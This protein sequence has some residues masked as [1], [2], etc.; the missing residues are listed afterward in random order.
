MIIKRN[1]FAIVILTLCSSVA[2]AQ[3][4]NRTKDTINTE[5]VNVVKPYTPKISDAFKVKEIPS[6]EDEVTENRKEVKY[7]IFSIPVAST[8]TPAKAKAAAV[9]KAEPVKLYDN[10]ASFGVGSYTSFLGEVYLNHAINSSETVGGYVSHHSSAGGIDGVVLDDNF[11]DT[12]FNAN[13]SRKSSDYSWNVDAGARHQVFNWYGIPDDVYD[14]AAISSIDPQHTYFTFD[15]GG[16]IE[17]EDRLL[18]DGR[19]RFRRFADDYDSGENRFMFSTNIDIP[20][21][22]GELNTTFKF[23]YLGGTFQRSLF[24]EEE[25]KYGNFQIGVV[26]SYQI[27]EDDLTVDLGVSAYYMKDIEADDNKFFIFPKVTAS[28]RLVDEILISYGG[29]EGD[30]IQNSYYDFASQNP[31][32]S[33]TLFIMPTDMQYD[34]YIGLKGKLSNNMSYNIRGNYKAENN[35]ALIKSNPAQIGEDENYQYG[36]S[37]GVVYDDVSTLSVFGEIN[38][39]VNRNFTLGIKAEYFNYTTDDEA[40]AWNRPDFEGSLFMDVQFDKHWF[41]GANLFYIG[42]RMDQMFV[43]DPLINSTPMTIALESYFDANA[44]LGYRINDAWT[45]YAKANN[46]ANQSYKRWLNYPVQ[47]FQALAG[48]TYKFDF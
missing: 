32:M 48:V 40:E 35:S 43:I 10:Y 3:E 26:P 41:A 7:N 22:D 37:F 45:V 31:F 23:D 34:A 29:I 2:F 39:N 19:M 17:F 8:F 4:N 5:V 38:V 11:S 46:I 15:F 47:G 36:N 25:L 1:H 12:K 16:E 27:K 6:L 14:D 33:P 21:R 9:D 44:H 13:Y 24:E 28:Y 18:N 30:L 42:E 20:L